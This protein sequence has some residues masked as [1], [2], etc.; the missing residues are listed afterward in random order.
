M[1]MGVLMSFLAHLQANEC[2]KRM[3]NSEDL[4]IEVMVLKSQNLK[5]D[6]YF[7]K[8]SQPGNFQMQQR[9]QTTFTHILHNNN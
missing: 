8:Y 4:A 5:T 2:T 7:L 1:L 6:S 9:N 3:Q